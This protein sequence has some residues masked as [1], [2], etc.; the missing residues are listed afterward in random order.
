MTFSKSWFLT[1]SI[2]AILSWEANRTE[3]VLPS[4]VTPTRPSPHGGACPN[5]QRD[6]RR[7]A[8]PPRRLPGAV[9]S[10]QSPPGSGQAPPQSGSA[11]H[12]WHGQPRQPSPETRFRLDGPRCPASPRQPTKGSGPAYGPCAR[13][14]PEAEAEAE[15]ESRRGPWLLR[16]KSSSPHINGVFTA[17]GTY[18]P[19][20]RNTRGS[21]RHGLAY[22]GAN[23]R[24]RCRAHATRSATPR[25]DTALPQ[26]LLIRPLV[27]KRAM[28]FSVADVVRAYVPC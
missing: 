10:G 6:R 28:K 5:W 9:P 17:S 1:A 23:P 8:R 3:S 22:V 19:C 14:S 13:P 15:A 4:L 27:L 21:Q 26:E 25:P 20:G 16:A 11:P 12:Q 18:S 24:P 7:L 2:S